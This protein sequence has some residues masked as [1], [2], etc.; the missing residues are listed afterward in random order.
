MVREHPA[1]H[2]LLAGRQIQLCGGQQRVAQDKLHVGERQRRIGGHP[3]GRGM[4]QR[5]QRRA[6]A[7]HRGGPLEHA[8]HRVIAQRPERPPQRPPQRQ[9]A[10][11]GQQPVHLDLIQPQ[12]HE[13][14]RRGRQR[15]HRPGPLPDAGDFGISPVSIAEIPH[16]VERS[17]SRLC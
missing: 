9:P 7:R 4:P 3:V 6:G 13:R 14:I 17:A 8:V 11:A 1:D 12:P 15:L 2:F 10:A 16:L 5:V